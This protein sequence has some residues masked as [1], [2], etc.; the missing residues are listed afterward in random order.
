[1]E[2]AVALHG[3]VNKAVP[4][5]GTL[6]PMASMYPF[7]V[8]AARGAVAEPPDHGIAAAAEPPD[9]GTAAAAEPADHGT[10]AAAVPAAPG[11]APAEPP[12]LGNSFICYCVSSERIWN[13]CV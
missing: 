1:M 7:P 10:A 3:V 11:T 9:H 4:V 2:V 12:A 6:I 5:D 13:E 8:V